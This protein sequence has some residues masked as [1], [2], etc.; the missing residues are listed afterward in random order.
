MKKDFSRMSL[1]EINNVH[2]ILITSNDV[3]I[4]L[5][6]EKHKEYIEFAQMGKIKDTEDVINYIISREE[7]VDKEAL[8]LLSLYN[9]I[10][11]KK[12]VLKEDRENFFYN[13]IIED[14]K[15]YFEGKRYSVYTL[16]TNGKNLAS[17]SIGE[18]CAEKLCANNDLGRFPTDREKKTLAKREEI[19][20]KLKSRR[21][22]KKNTNLDKITELE[23]DVEMVNI[24]RPLLMSDVTYSFIDDPKLGLILRWIISKNTLLEVGMDSYEINELDKNNTIEDLILDEH[25]EEYL[26]QYEKTIKENVDHIDID[27]LL[28]TSACRYMLVL[29]DR[30]LKPEEIE[31]IKE[32]LEF[33]SKRLE[34][35]KIRIELIMEE[36][37]EDAL[38]LR[39]TEKD[40]KEQLKKFI[41]PGIYLGEALIEE[42]KND[43][44]T[45]EKKLSE[46]NPSILKKI[47]Y[48]FN[49]EESIS[50][51]TNSR[52]NFI[53]I[54]ENTNIGKD[55]IK[56]LIEQL[57]K[58]DNEMIDKLVGKR[59]LVQDDIIDLFSQGKIEKKQLFEIADKEIIDDNTIVKIYYKQKEEQ[60]EENLILSKTE[61]LE[62][63]NIDKIKGYIENNEI[64]KEFLEFYK[65]ILP[66]NK[67]EKQKILSQINELLIKYNNKDLSKQFYI[68]G[69]L[70]TKNIGEKI[71]ENDIISMFENEQIDFD[72]IIEMYNLDIISETSMNLLIDFYDLSEQVIEKLDLAEISIDKL[73]K[74]ELDLKENYI[75]DRYM[76]K[77]NT[78]NTCYPAVIGLSNGNINLKQLDELYNLGKVKEEDLFEFAMKGLFDQKIVRD[79]YINSL[80]SDEKLEQLCLNGIISEKSKEFAKKTRNMGQLSKNIDKKLGM[81]I[82]DDGIEIDDTIIL[83]LEKKGEKIER[84]IDLYGDGTTKLPKLKKVIEPS[85]RDEKIKSLGGKKIKRDYVEYDEKSPFNDYEFYI[86]PTEI[87]EITPDCIVIAERYYED[88]F[89]DEEKLIDGNATYLFKL[90]DLTRISKKSKPE[91]IS[92]MQQQKDNTMSR[93]SHTKYWGKNLDEVIEKISGKKMKSKYTPEELKKIN[94]IN[95][96]I[97]GFEDY[98]NNNEYTR[99]F[100]VFYY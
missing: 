14:L 97:D 73:D 31:D 25:Y 3:F 12:T 85:A 71:P 9:A 30:I 99:P 70:E 46:I 41:E 54:I 96:L 45:G 78:F 43:L 89:N 20:N 16:E 93:I 68:A 35:K 80:I 8:L 49:D 5:D 59:L 56:L 42:S 13:K 19:Y 34:N 76:Q 48:F 62:Y 82:Y 44:L 55:D 24:L 29:E 66:E 6:N 10:E 57:S 36:S 60:F 37:E 26:K 52:E 69:L 21:E 17:D 40:L 61:L 53:Y 47:I 2:G 51:M 4:I 88:K 67:E 15:E 92:L 38:V 74:L 98:T 100:D 18:I 64:E 65:E 91:I 81:H 32:Y 94:K 22:K 77:E 87:G 84:V 83:P 95:Q 86:I 7:Y 28:L 23:K 33:V 39:Y 90:G 72:K 50:L 1:E 63:F 79:I 58:L 11:I 75:Y 27:K